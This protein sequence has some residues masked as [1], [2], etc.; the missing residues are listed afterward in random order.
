[1]NIFLSYARED[2]AV[3]T[4]LVALIDTHDVWY[5]QEMKGGDIVW[6]VIRYRISWCDVMLYLLSVESVESE[7]CLREFRMAVAKGK[8]VIPILVSHQLKMD[9]DSLPEDI[10]GIQILDLRDGFTQDF[11]IDIFSS[12][13]N[14]EYGK[15]RE[16]ARANPATNPTPSPV[17]AEEEVPTSGLDKD[18]YMARFVE[19]YE[20][21]N[22]KLAR[23]IIQHAIK[24]KFPAEF[25]S[26]TD[27]LKDVESK[28]KDQ[29]QQDQIAV[30]YTH[31]V[32]LVRSSALRAH[33]C[34][35]FYDFRKKYPDYDPQGL[36]SVCGGVE[37]TTPVSPVGITTIGDS[38]GSNGA[39]HPHQPDSKRWLQME[40]DQLE[41][42]FIDIPGGKSMTKVS[43][44]G[45]SA[46]YQS[47]DAFRITEFPTTNQ[48]FQKFV[49]DKHGYKN[50]IWWR[51]SKHAYKWWKYN[52]AREPH[53]PGD[54]NPR[55]NV[56]WYEAIAF[57]RWLSD[58]LGF[59]VSLPTKAQWQRAAQG[60]NHYIYPWGDEFNVSYCNTRESQI[61]KTTSVMRY[62]NGV[63]Q[64]GIMDMSGNVWEWLLDT[65]DGYGYSQALDI[66]APRLLLGGAYSS[67][68]DR[69]KST[70][71]FSMTP[72]HYYGTAGFRMVAQAK[73]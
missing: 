66:E 10:M 19:A 12:L 54:H 65:P 29:D 6:E 26:L 57:T 60:D 13:Y 45:K 24:N 48:Q 37:L 61:H 1:M 52:Q 9:S 21:Q 28:I 68:G 58:K 59:E 63:S 31:I 32:Q 39:S 7:A 23:F 20:K 38:P 46:Q 22:F 2:I 40:R 49:D 25:F 43:R 15:Q 36:R 4:E 72:D 27:L 70:D 11:K 18:N 41:P 14:I 62:P 67:T 47:V 69:A 8:P 53:F 55:N 3:C 42:H 51:F 44:G 34:Q 30:M 17:K 16:L 71:N 64:F 35:S 50:E 5:D 33:G 56:C 73:Q